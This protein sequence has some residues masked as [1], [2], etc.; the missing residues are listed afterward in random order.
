LE[1]KR[2]LIIACSQRK[3]PDPGL[4]PAIERYDGPTF[5]VLRKFLL[6]R[7]NG[8]QFV[9]TFILSGNFGL[10]SASHPTPNYDYKMSRQ[11]A[12]ELQTKVIQDFE[13]V[14]QAT[15]Y[16]ELFINLGQSYWQALAGYERLV[17]AK[18]KIIIAQGSQGGR[19]AKLHHWLYNDLVQPPNG[20][21]LIAQPSKACIRGIE[22][23]LTS[24]QVLDVTRQALA[25]GR[26][27]PTNY[28]SAFVWV[29]GQR[30]APKWL[31]SQLTGLPVGSFHTGDARR[32]LQQ[33][34][35]EVRSI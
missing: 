16:S 27:D 28:Q 8:A 13:Q 5:R 12:Q 18:T 31:V 29:D 14:I 34:G 26:G 1:P 9:D 6:E 24:E 25:E 10:I 2:L 33:L 19:Q 15:S 23:T 22:I 7:P 11:R 32:V 17:P 35:I 3:R 30:V 4:L 21:S 20:Q